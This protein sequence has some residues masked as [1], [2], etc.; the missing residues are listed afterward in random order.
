[1]VDSEK[2]PLV[3]ILIPLYNAFPYIKDMLDS[4]LKQSYD[5]WEL[6]IVDDGS[7]D[8][9]PEIV[10]RYEK[11]DYRIKYIKRP[12]TRKKGGNTCRN[13]AFENSN[14]EYVI[15]FDADDLIAPYCLEQRLRYMQ[16]HL[17][18]DF[19]V[20]PALGFYENLGNWSGQYFGY[21]S[22]RKA[23]NNL[24]NKNLPFAVWT[25]IY[26]KDS[27][28]KNKILWDEK[29]ISLQDSDFN[30]TCLYKNLQFK[31]FSDCADYFWRQT[32]NSISTKINGSKHCSNH[33]YFYNKT[34]N[35]FSKNKELNRDLKLASLWTFEILN[36]VSKEWGDKLLLSIFFNKNKFFK[37]KIQLQRKL[38][39]RFNNPKIGIL[40]KFSIFPILN[41]KKIYLNKSFIFKYRNKRNLSILKESTDL[42]LNFN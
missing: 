9:G 18:L 4:I 11:N 2:K 20:F 13:I 23:I 32:P 22:E 31:E 41:L 8:E 40:I 39:S 34:I 30:L 27:L 12:N 5:N 15:W 42:A 25:N 24:I 28:I 1:M 6:I 7:T 14:G 37:K 10:K 16:E 19:A 38:I 21:K 35:Y 36:T 33:I 3:S 26:K 17:D 29:L